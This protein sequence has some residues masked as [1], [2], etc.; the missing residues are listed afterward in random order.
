MKAA[1]LNRKMGALY[2]AETAN[3]I[4]I[5]K[6]CT[7]VQLTGSAKI[8]TYQAGSGKS[9]ALRYYAEHNERAYYMQIEPHYTQKVFL[10]KFCEVLGLPIASSSA[11]MIDSIIS[12]LSKEAQAIVIFDEFDKILDK[13]N[14]FS[15]FKTLYDHLSGSCGFVI[16]G[17]EFLEKDI[18]KRVQA[19]KMGYTELFSRCGREFVY[20]SAV[21]KQDVEAICRVNGINSE[22]I[23]QEMFVQTSNGDLRLLE[24]L[25]TKANMLVREKVKKAVGE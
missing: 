1:K 18:F 4:K 8:L 23:I 15:I 12:F 20:L 3:F 22:S 16:C 25:I 14:V 2:L 19:F 17:T 10:R 21:S 11:E 6:L 13:K 24:N 7:Y 5:T 9:V